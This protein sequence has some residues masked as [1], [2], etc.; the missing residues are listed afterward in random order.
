MYVIP[1]SW[2]MKGGQRWATPLLQDAFDQFA[3]IANTLI[4]VENEGYAVVLLGKTCAYG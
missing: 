3:D 1:T 4:T 2:Q